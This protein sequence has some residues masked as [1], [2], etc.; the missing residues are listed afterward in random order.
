M[1][2]PA[3]LRDSETFDLVKKNLNKRQFDLDITESLENLVQDRLSQLHAVEVLQSQRN[4][5][6]KEIGT[7]K[8][9][10]PD[11]DIEPLKAE[12]KQ[13]GDKI[14]DLKDSLETTEEKYQEALLSLPNMLEEDVPEGSS[15]EE[16]RTVRTVGEIPRYDFQVMPHYE[17]AEALD[18]VDFPGGVKLA[19]SR[20]YVYNEQVARLERELITFMLNRHSEAGYKERMVPLLVND[21]CMRGTGQYPK[22]AD[23]YYR[24]ERDELNLIPTAE[25]PLTNLYADTI[26]QQDDLPINL[27]AA[28]S[29]FRREAGSAGKDTRGLVRVH[30][31][32]KVELVK[33]V[34]PQTS[35]DELEKLLA[36][37]ED[38]LKKLGLTYRVQLLC[39]GDTSFSSAKTY[40]LEVFM[41]GLDRWL[42][43]SSVSNFKDFQARRA[44]IRYKNNDTRKNELVHTLNGSGV[45]AG[46]LVAALLE[47]HQTARGEIDWQSIYAK[48][49]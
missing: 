49:S 46:R 22:F 40:D 21:D 28:T 47:Y 45:A 31:F 27:T 32:Q 8:A 5:M 14:K 18:L 20:F 24:L 1:I 17:I 30:Q 35:A 33:F 16:N 42:E 29:C 26:L 3:L 37:A 13:T 11:A 4:L 48:I 34:H 7:M 39:A 25:V 6:S 36:D 19:G 43:I 12:V 23:E 38:I 10:N 15:D 9:E 2:D 41:P 44:K